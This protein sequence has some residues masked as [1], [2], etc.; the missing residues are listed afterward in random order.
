MAFQC[1]QAEVQTC[2]CSLLLQH[3]LAP[4]P[5]LSP[6]TPLCALC[7]QTTRNFSRSRM[8][9]LMTLSH[10]SLC[11]LHFQPHLTIL[12]HPQIS[13][14]PRNLPG[15]QS[16]DEIHPLI[17]YAQQPLAQAFHCTRSTVSE[18]LLSLTQVI[19]QY[20]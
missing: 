16:Q 2:Y 3:M 1:P 13:L 11:L 6:A 9:S 10:A 12:T 19:L 20:Y 5:A 17:R 18:S 7:Q 8:C 15:W 14:P 4:L